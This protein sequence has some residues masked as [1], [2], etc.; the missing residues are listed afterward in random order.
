MRPFSSIA[1]AFALARRSACLSELS[2]PM[3]RAALIDQGDAIRDRQSRSGFRPNSP[4]RP[5]RRRPIRVRWSNITRCRRTSS[6]GSARPVSPI[7][8]SRR[9]P[10]SRRPTTM[11]FAPPTIRFQISRATATSTRTGSP[12][13]RSRSA[14]RS[15]AMPTMRAAAASIRQP[16]HQSRPR[17]RASGSHRGDRIRSPFAPTPAPIY[18][19]SSPTSRNLR[20]LRQAP[21][22]GKRRKGRD[23]DRQDPGRTL[24]Q[25]GRRP[26]AD[27]AAPAAARGPASGRRQGNLYDEKVV[28]A[29]KQLPASPWQPP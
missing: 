4:P 5:T 29:V 28:E 10:R 1:L 6:S 8:P 7:A 15:L 17:P 9:S 21:A 18:G 23:G 26:R 14:S 12:R 25:A 27:R 16:Q 19:A 24:A 22:R 20:R 13:P 2:S 3:R 11:A